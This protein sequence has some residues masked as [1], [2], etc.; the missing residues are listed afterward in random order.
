MRYPHSY[1]LESNLRHTLSLVHTNATSQIQKGVH[2]SSGSN[3]EGGASDEV[4]F[5]PVGSEGSEDELDGEEDQLPKSTEKKNAAADASKDGGPKTLKKAQFETVNVPSSFAKELIGVKGATIS[6]IKQE[7]GV[8]KLEV[9]HHLFGDP[10]KQSVRIYGVSESIA[11]VKSKI[12]EMLKAGSGKQHKVPIDREPVGYYDSEDEV[13]GE[14][15]DQAPQGSE[16]N[17]A[18]ASNDGGSK[19]LKKPQY[20]IVNVPSSFVKEL[21]GPKGATITA[22][23]QECGATKVSFSDEFGEPPQFAVSI[24]GDLK[25]I[26]KVKSKIEEMLSVKQHIVHRPPIFPQDALLDELFGFSTDDPIFKFGGLE[27]MTPT[28]E[29]QVTFDNHVFVCM[30]RVQQQ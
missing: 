28:A 6:A 24:L 29:V 7:C 3:P 17:A 15:E 27:K 16:K 26:A 19:T 20:G 4:D 1:L 9:S 23:K 5:E 30:G 8:A 21:I 13:D 14:E 25:S 2:A 11:K 12:E 18:D 10:P 22:I